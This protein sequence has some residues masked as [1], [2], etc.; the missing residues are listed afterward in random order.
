MDAVVIE[1]LA[2]S[3]DPRLRLQAAHDPL[4]PAALLELLAEDPSEEVRRQAAIHPNCPPKTQMRLARQAPVRD[5]ILA[6]P[7][8]VQRET[9]RMLLSRLSTADI[10]RLLVDTARYDALPLTRAEIRT[11][12]DSTLPRCIRDDTAQWAKAKFHEMYVS[13]ALGVIAHVA[14]QP[15]VTPVDIDTLL[16]LVPANSGRNRFGTAGALHALFTAPAA[17]AE[18][19]A[20]ILDRIDGPEDFIEELAEDDSVATACLTQLCAD[21]R[22]TTTQRAREVLSRLVTTAAL[23]DGGLDDSLADRLRALGVVPADA[24]RTLTPEH[25]DGADAL[26]LYQSVFKN[27]DDRWFNESVACVATVPAVLAALETQQDDLRV[28]YGLVCNRGY[29]F[30]TRAEAGVFD[31]MLTPGRIPERREF[32]AN[33]GMALEHLLYELFIVDAADF[34]RAMNFVERLVAAHPGLDR[35]ERPGDSTSASSIGMALGHFHKCMPERY[36]LVVDRLIGM[37]LTDESLHNA[38]REVVWRHRGSERVLRFGIEHDKEVFAFDDDRS[39]PAD[40]FAYHLITSPACPAEHLHAALARLYT[41]VASES[42]VSLYRQAIFRHPNFDPRPLVEVAIEARDSHLARDLIGGLLSA[43][44]FTELWD[45]SVCEYGM[46]ALRSEIIGLAADCAGT[47]PADAS[48]WRELDS[49]D[50]L[51]TSMFLFA[52][53]DLP[54]ALALSFFE[55]VVEEPDGER[56]VVIRDTDDGTYTA[57]RMVLEAQTNPRLLAAAYASCSVQRRAALRQH[58]ITYG[59]WRIPTRMHDLDPAARVAYESF[60]G[61]LIVDHAEARVEAGKSLRG[62]AGLLAEANRRFLPGSVEH[63]RETLST[64]KIL[65]EVDSDTLEQMQGALTERPAPEAEAS[66]A[67]DPVFSL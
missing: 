61:T 34:D 3:F 54:E 13:Y 63:L 29:D 28:V 25:F 10:Y 18:Q 30:L 53:A 58:A 17:T 49:S 1:A 35:R 40:T 19:R 9:R 50:L 24:I 56:H 42:V 48:I 47:F 2:R 66:T 64:S 15:R 45:R 57:A 44:L 22:F 14:E 39:N 62:M 51:T 26:A 46:G 6:Q 43:E 59:A 41:D 5:A 27:D 52:R 37:G 20:H 33:Q 23:I 8:C 4:A 32:D 16:E 60:I 21:Q 36:D 38:V 55:T 31:W 65:T 11:L 67:L 7:D 12:L